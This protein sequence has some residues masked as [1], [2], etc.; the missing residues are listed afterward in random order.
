[1]TSPSKLGRARRVRHNV[2]IS[3]RLTAKERE[4]VE[5]A[6]QQAYVP[7]S[8]WVRR[9]LVRAAQTADAAPASRGRSR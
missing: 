8:A 9:A 7:L 1:M 4:Q 2:A 3:V 6:A 5:S